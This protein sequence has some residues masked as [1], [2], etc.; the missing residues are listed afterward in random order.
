M[1]HCFERDRESYQSI[2]IDNY[3][4]GNSLIKLLY[5][6]LFFFCLDELV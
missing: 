3:T 4:Q 2:I 1:V 5:G 6:D